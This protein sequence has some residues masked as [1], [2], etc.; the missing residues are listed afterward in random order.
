M[1]PPNPRV[2]LVTGANTGIGRETARVLA[3]R[4]FEVILACRSA[5]RADAVVHA[6]RRETGGARVEGLTLDLASLASVRRA[7]ATFL[8]SGRPLHVLLNNA[9]LAGSRGSTEDGFE[10]AFGVNHLG[11]FLLT[12]LLL[13]RLIESAPARVVTVSSSAHYQATGIDFEALTRSTRSLT[14]VREYRVSKLA[15]VLFTKELALR[16][17]GTGVDA[18][19]LDPGV[20][21]TD[22]WR[23][24]PWPIRPLVTRRMLSLAEGSRT[25]VHL[26]TADEASLGSG[27]YFVDCAPRAPSALAQ[28][29]ALAAE[30]WRRSEAWV[31]D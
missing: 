20:V 11:H 2:A 7:A 29:D 12:R 15:N 23:R 17:D 10:I 4:G 18:F 19:A 13:D 16:L 8:G 24:I 9:G 27:D 31:R 22:I 21:A 6:I 5:E 14:G 3:Q 28:D 1:P 26:A 30:L 25:S